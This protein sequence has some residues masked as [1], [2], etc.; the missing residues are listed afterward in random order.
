MNKN[1]L[2]AA[3]VEKSELTKKEAATLIWLP[4]Q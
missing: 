1:E 2:I 4:D 3:M